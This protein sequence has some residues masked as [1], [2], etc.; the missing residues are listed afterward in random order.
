MIQSC[1]A[2]QLCTDDPVH[3]PITPT[4]LSDRPRQ[5]L[6]CD[7]FILSNDDEVIDV[8][9]NYSRFPFH[10]PQFLL[11]YRTSPHQT[12]FPPAVLLFGRNISSKIPQLIQHGCRLDHLA[13]ETDAKN[14]R[15]DPRGRP[16]RM[17]MPNSR[18]RDHV[19]ELP[20]SLIL[21]WDGTIVSLSCPS[22]RV[23]VSLL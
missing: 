8:I 12:G 9:D 22:S 23:P 4:K 2:C 10:L 3:Q 17:R 11:D 1:P 6:S 14:E 20:Q 5:V 7:F 15:F 21:R 13:R 18:L 16:Q 19:V